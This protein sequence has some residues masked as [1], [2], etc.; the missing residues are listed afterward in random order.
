MKLLHYVHRKMERCPKNQNKSVHG[1]NE[2]IMGT[3]SI[4]GK[5]ITGKNLILFSKDTK[6]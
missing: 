6:T 1:I 2:R 5:F 3:F 4:S